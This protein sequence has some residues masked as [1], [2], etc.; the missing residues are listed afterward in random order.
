MAAMLGVTGQGS[1]YFVC[2]DD[3]VS[4]CFGHLFEM[5]MPEDYNPAFKKWNM[6]DLP[7]LPHEWPVRAKAKT[8]ERIT[9]LGNLM[10]D[11]SIVVNAGDPD[12]E[13]QLLVDDV[14]EHHGFR[15]Q[16]LRFWASAQDPASL[17]YALDNMQDNR[18][19]SGMRDAARARGRLAAGPVGP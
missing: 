17:A 7:I 14:I 12:N 1:G 10:N 15:G 19:R 6:E 4:S 8:Q 11:V 13:G 5:L 16:V 3:L 2:G 18:E 9:L